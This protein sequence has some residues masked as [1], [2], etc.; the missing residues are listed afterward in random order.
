MADS[1]PPPETFVSSKMPAND[2][3]GQ[4]GYRGASSDLPGE[5]TTSGFLPQTKLEAGIKADDWQLRKVA[6]TAYPTHPGMH[7]PAGGEKVPTHN[8]RAVTKAAAK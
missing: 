3:Y 8:F 5:K 7:A 6:P 1:N 2:G 4:N